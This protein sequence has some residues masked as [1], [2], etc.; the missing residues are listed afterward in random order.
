MGS[1]KKSYQ[2][3]NINGEEH[4]K[5]EANSKEGRKCDESLQFVALNGYFTSKV[6]LI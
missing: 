6:Y 5:D 3:Y 2:T 1:A 4:K